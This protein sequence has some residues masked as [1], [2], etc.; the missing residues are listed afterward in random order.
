MLLLLVKL[1][2]DFLHWVEVFAETEFTGGWWEEVVF[3]V[4][5]DGR[6]PGN[7]GTFTDVL[8]G[9]DLSG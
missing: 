9:V 2:V 6:G 5:D 1:I 8:D 4:L 3:A 7:L